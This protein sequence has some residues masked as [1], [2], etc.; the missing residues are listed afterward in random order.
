MCLESAMIRSLLV[1]FAPPLFAATASAQ[2]SRSLAFTHVTVVDV[3]GGS[4]RPDVLVIIQGNRITAVADSGRAPIPLNTHVIDARGKYLIPGLWDMHVHAVSP[5]NRTTFMPLFVANGVTG[6]R[7]MFGTVALVRD[8]RAGRNGGI[9]P[10]V[11]GSGH[12][13]DGA[14]PFW[15]GSV[16]VGTAD[17][18]RHAVDSLHQAGADFIKVYGL[19]SREVFFAAAERARELGIPFA[20]H[21]PESVSA[22]E[23]SDAGQRAIE[24]LSGVLRSCST[25]EENLRVEM[26]QA[27][28]EHDRNVLLAALRNTSMAALATY[29]DEKCAALIA[30]FARNGT[31]HAPTLTVRR[32]RAFLDDTVLTNDARLRYMLPAIRAGWLPGENPR[33]RVSPVEMADR[34]RLY[35][36]ELELVALLHRAGVP[37]LAGTDTPNPY[38]LPGFGLHDELAL[39]VAAGLTPLEALRTATLNPARFLGALDSLGTV[40]PGK[41]A[42]LVLLD[43]DPLVDIAN[44]QRIAAIVVNGQLVDSATRRRLL[45]EV[46]QIAN[47]P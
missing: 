18:A 6:V 4:L 27:I 2:V 36:K 16:A 3:L 9:G 45:A 1:L 11:V 29:D 10:R 25:R 44:T 12:I 34:K 37:I 7:E 38:A 47:R 30:R 28:A 26:E 41:L 31:W 13:L 35:Q 42:D 20:G 19:L 23:A 46:E 33:N 22:A 5:R 24:H 17:A 43:A 8:A 21:V 32:G 40:A 15:P 39:L 14:A